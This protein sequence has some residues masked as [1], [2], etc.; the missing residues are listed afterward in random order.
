MNKVDIYLAL[1]SISPI[2]KVWSV[3]TTK[4]VQSR[5]LCPGA[6]YI[7]CIDDARLGILGI[8][9][10]RPRWALQNGGALAFRRFA[11]SRP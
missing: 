7:L 6:N 1:F 3:L 11:H 10:L 8:P 5:T 4:G 2:V 9:V